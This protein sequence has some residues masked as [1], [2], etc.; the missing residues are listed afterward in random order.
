M[1]KLTIEQM[2]FILGEMRKYQAEHPKAKV[3]YYTKDGE[4]RI[5]YPLPADYF[6]IK[7]M[8]IAE[9]RESRLTGSTDL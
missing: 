1:E 3:Y 6:E 5:T 8:T 4:V 7:P 2:E 9:I